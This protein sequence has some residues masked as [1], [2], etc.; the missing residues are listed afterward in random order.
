MKKILSFLLVVV[1][2][3]VLCS[4]GEPD[5]TK[6][7]YTYLQKEILTVTGMRN[8]RLSDVDMRSMNWDG[9]EVQKGLVFSLVEDLTG[10]GIPEIITGEETECDDFFGDENIKNSAINIKVY[11]ISKGK[12]SFID[13][14]EIPQLLP[15]FSFVDITFKDK[16]LFISGIGA[17]AGD[18]P[19]NN[20]Y[21]I[22]FD[23]NSFVQDTLSSFDIYTWGGYDNMTDDEK[24]NVD[25]E[26]QKLQDFGFGY[27]KIDDLIGKY[28]PSA[29]RLAFYSLFGKDGR[30]SEYFAGSDIP[31]KGFYDYTR[32]KY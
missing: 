10:D 12:V 25:T 3:L 19:F 23:G 31:E 11:G 7:C 4:C 26:L 20:H 2:M 30:S 17:W 18:P 15:L 14:T 32:R 5:Y 28:D 21:I 13:E 1:M 16:T 29:K 24:R 22:R 9:Y 27:K 8:G 6:L